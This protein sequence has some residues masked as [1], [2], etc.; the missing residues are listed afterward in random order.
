[1]TRASKVQS[2]PETKDFMDTVDT[3]VAGKTSLFRLIRR[4]TGD[5]RTF[6]RQAIQ[7]AKTEVLENVG[8]LGR[9]GVRL[10]I[11]GLAAYAGLI[12]FLIG[13]GWLGAW[14]FQLAGVAPFLAAFLGMVA[15][16]IVVVAA[17]ALFLM[18]A[19][20][21]LSAK[22]LAPQKTLHTLQEL[23]GRRVENGYEPDETGS[24]AS[25]DEM[26]SRVEATENRMGETLDELGYRLSPSHLNA[27]MKDRIQAN[28]YRAG[29]IAMGAG[30]LGGMILV[31]K[32]RRE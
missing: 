1:M 18:K 22:S 17:G 4:L 13:L 5:T 30:I 32:S 7:L 23:K 27:V 24:P 29:M 12:V 3:A 21:S 14:L 15:V 31:R 8:R 16:G 19:I 9:N 2:P 11:G 20:R 26:Q 25:S 6:I 10:A 28:P